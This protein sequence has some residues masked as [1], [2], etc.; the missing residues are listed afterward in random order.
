[1]EMKSEM[2]EL[3]KITRW[4]SGGTPSRSIAEYWVGDIPWISAFTLKNIEVSESD[5]CVTAEAVAS[6]SKMAPVDST[7]LLVR[8]SALHNE[9]R[10]GIVRKPVCFNQDVKALIPVKTVYPKY[11]TY[12]VLGREGDLLKLVSSAGNTAGVLDTKL[13]VFQNM[14]SKI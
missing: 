6:G 2:V 11:L 5:Q 9:V 13:A 7:L 12:S 3:G 8:G 4:L 1:M 10:A 14:A